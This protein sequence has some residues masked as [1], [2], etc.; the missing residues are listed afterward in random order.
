MASV[1]GQEILRSLHERNLP[2]TT[3]AVGNINNVNKRND[4]SLPDSYQP[5]RASA[6]QDHFLGHFI[7]AF[8]NP[9]TQFDDWAFR[10]PDFL[11][12]PQSASLTLSIRAATMALYGKK[13]GNE[14]IQMEACRHYAKGLE[15]QLLDSKAHQLKM[16]NGGQVAEIFNE[17]TIC[18]TVMFS[19]FE[20]IMS[21]SI[22]GWAQHLAAAGKMME[23]LGPERCRYGIV[24][25]LFRTVRV[26]T[27]SHVP[28]TACNSSRTYDVRSIMVLHGTNPLCLPTRNGALSL[29]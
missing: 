2:I 12:N 15:S 14:S 13:S 22:T 11:E 7:M 9:R 16:A 8:F 19:F 4:F 1:D 10:I 26:G 3:T 25:N 5:S 17:E 18:A 29:F 6:F 20:S 24:H 28:A 21:T 23:M 27:V